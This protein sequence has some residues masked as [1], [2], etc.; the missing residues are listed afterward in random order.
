MDY[1][2][3]IR[4]LT[5]SAWNQG[6][7]KVVEQYLTSDWRL[8]DPT[9]PNA[10]PGPAQM[11]EM[12]K[13]YRAAFPDMKMTIDQLLVE[14]DYVVARWTSRG[15]HNGALFGAAPSHRKVTV[16]GIQIDRFKGDKIVESWVN[17]DTAGMMQQ[18]GVMP[19]LGT[20]AST[21]AAR[22]AGVHK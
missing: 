10:Q 2:E 17:W 21:T 14:G 5:E 15:T 13:Q 22:G 11:I 16:T 1:K 3:T 12:I 4:R 18:I 19:P 20:G 6:D 7:T 8:H 9:V